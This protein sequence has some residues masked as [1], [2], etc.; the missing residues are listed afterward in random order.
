MRQNSPLGLAVAP[1]V[2][3]LMPGDGYNQDFPQLTS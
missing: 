2:I 1:I 3:S